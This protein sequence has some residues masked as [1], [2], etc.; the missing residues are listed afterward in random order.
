M[1]RIPGLIDEGDAG[2]GHIH[3]ENIG[4]LT[5]FFCPVIHFLL[6]FSGRII[7]PRIAE[8]GEFFYL[9]HIDSPLLCLA[10]E[11]VDGIAQFRQ[12][13]LNGGGS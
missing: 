6:N 1:A 11:M 4:V 2:R 8:S 12:H 3:A 10:V 13:F 7:R 5:M 9:I